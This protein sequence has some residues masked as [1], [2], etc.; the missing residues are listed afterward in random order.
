ML[1]GWSLQQKTAYAELVRRDYS[2]FV[3]Y[4]WDAIEPGTPLTWNWHIDAVCQALSRVATGEI[5]RLVICIPPGTMKSTLVS[6]MLDP[7]IWLTRP[8]ERTLTASYD[9]SLATRDNVKA[10]RIVE[11]DK[12]QEL[13]R[14]LVPLGYQAWGFTDDQNQKT[15]F[16]TTRGGF[17]QI[18]TV[19]GGATG[20]RGDKTIVDDPHKLLDILQAAPSRQLEL[21]QEV[22]EWYNNVFNSRL[23]DMATG[24]QIVIMQR[25]HMEDLAGSLI[26]SGRYHVLQL[27]MEYDP[28]IADPADIRT[29]PGELLFPSKF[30]AD[31]V[32]SLK[33]TMLPEQYA[34]QYGQA[35][36]P[37]EGGLVRKEWCSNR[38]QWR[39][40]WQTNT[41][42]PKF[43]R[44]VLSGD[45]AVKAKQLSDPSVF[46]L[47]GQSESNNLYL[48]LVWRKRLEYA[49]L[50]PA[51]ENL[52][53]ELNPSITLIEDAASGAQLASRLE[54][55]GYKI[56]RMQPYADKYVRMSSQTPWFH[57]SKVWFPTNDC[58]WLADYLKELGLFPQVKHD[59]QV[60]STSQALKYFD[61]FKDGFSYA[62]AGGGEYVDSEGNVTKI[63]DEDEYMA[64]LS[65]RLMGFVMPGEHR[66]YHEPGGFVVG[67]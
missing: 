38:Y 63:E 6:A 65:S 1:S 7:W 28:D 14:L 15:Y 41:A 49:D 60:D 2:L 40:E 54:R 45:T 8:E 24:R 51:V 17:R 16:E 5:Q 13:V 42:L 19:G 58:P 61:D 31:V 11:S 62:I 10:R 27:P 29:E 20:K 30:T 43:K 50:E 59:D 48:L 64:S 32:D 35:P 53:R 22:R 44:L 55:A 33:R 56:M 4:L 52:I 34:A 25:V 12:Y 18:V 67:D 39:P 21:V 26:A 3:K 46:T 37:S 23:N 66:S 36:V 47:W 57:S 9:A